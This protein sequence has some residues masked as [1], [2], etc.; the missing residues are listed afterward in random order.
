M[1]NVIMFILYFFFACA[2]MVLIK[3]GGQSTRDTL[4]N[5]PV[6]DLSVSLLSLLGFVFYGLSFLLYAALLTKYELSFLNPVTIGI[7][8]VLI[9]VSAVIFFGET[10]T[11][12]RVLGLA[13]ILVGVF[14]INAFK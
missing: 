2:G 3:M 10:I 7:T 12:A 13:V 11:V 6:I 4:F 9:F 1:N 5:L 14:I 8:S